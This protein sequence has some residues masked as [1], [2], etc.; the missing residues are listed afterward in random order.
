MRTSAID[1]VTVAAIAIVA[2][3]CGNLL[4]EA[5][6]HGGA[7]LLVGGRPQMLNAVFF[8]C[9]ESTLSPLGIRL[10]AAGGTI[11]N[12]I[13]AGGLLAWMRWSSGS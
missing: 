10:V 11:V 7:C 9:D 12:L 13:V 8:Q 5:V 2:Y 6:G 1:R 3:A 4:H